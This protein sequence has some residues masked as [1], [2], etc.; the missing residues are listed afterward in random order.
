MRASPRG[1][2]GGDVGQVKVL[3]PTLLEAAKLALRE[4]TRLQRIGRGILSIPECTKTPELGEDAFVD[5][6]GA[7][8]CVSGPCASLRGPPHPT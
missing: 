5:L 3:G 6:V 7:S 1:G 4:A 8:A 2:D